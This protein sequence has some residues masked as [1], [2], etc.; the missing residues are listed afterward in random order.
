MTDAVFILHAPDSI[1]V[2]TYICANLN[3]SGISA[4]TYLQAVGESS[5]SEVQA[6]WDTLAEFVPVFLILASPGLFQDSFLVEMA[7]DVLSS[8][9]ALPVIYGQARDLPT[10]FSH[11]ALTLSAK[12][13]EAARG[14][15]HL[16]DALSRFIGTW[17]ISSP[18]FGSKSS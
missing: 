1:G 8:K 10:W 14:W 9:K 16:I 4:I 17:S 18:L 2:A 6:N 3:Q 15:N 13:K 7:R 12:K 11:Q 5:R